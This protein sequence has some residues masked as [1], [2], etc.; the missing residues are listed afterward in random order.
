[1]AVLLLK[2]L[3]SSI[4]AFRSTLDSLIQSNRNFR[5]ALDSGFVPIG[6]TE[7]RLLSGQSFDAETCWRSCNKRSSVD[8]AGRPEGGA[9]PLD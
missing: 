8:G 9:G 6:R 4:E 2:R 7:T 1:M 5:E 3:E